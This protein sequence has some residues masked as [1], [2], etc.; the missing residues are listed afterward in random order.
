MNSRSNAFAESRAKVVLPTPGGPHK[1]ME[2]GLPEANARLSGLP[3]ANKWVCPITSS[4]VFGRNASANGGGG[5]LSKRP[6]IEPSCL[7]KEND[8]GRPR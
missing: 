6:L 7:D 1:I 4:I 5:V 3:R 2:C 8:D